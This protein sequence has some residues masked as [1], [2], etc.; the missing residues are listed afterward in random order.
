[1][2]L[3]A[4]RVDSSQTDLQTREIVYSYLFGEQAA[5]VYVISLFLS[6]LLSPPPLSLKSHLP[7]SHICRLCHSLISACPAE[8]VNDCMNEL[9]E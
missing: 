5:R 1:M 8:C 2:I 4:Q 3:P 9:H 6:S 7:L